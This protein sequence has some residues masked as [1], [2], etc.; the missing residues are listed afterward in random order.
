MKTRVLTAVVLVSVLWIP[1]AFARK[2]EFY[3]FAG[4]R[5]G[6]AVADET[7]IAYDLDG[8]ASYGLGLEFALSAEARLQLLWSHQSTGVDRFSF[9]DDGRVDLDIDYFHV[10]TAYV[11][12]PWSRTR[13]YLGMTIGATQVAAVDE[14]SSGTYFSFGINGGVKYLFNDHVGLRLDGRLFGTYG[15]SGAF[16]VGC[17]GGCFIAFSGDFFWQAEGTVGLVIAF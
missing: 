16:A 1:N 15:G 11:F 9:E 10:G 3:P 6:G 12:E 5:F 14:D 17:S 8:S 7:G 4:L 13:P 2:V